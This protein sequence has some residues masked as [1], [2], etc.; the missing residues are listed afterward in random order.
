MKQVFLFGIARE[1]QTRCF[2]TVYTVSCQRQSCQDA[3]SVRVHPKVLPI[4][5][6]QSGGQVCKQQNQINLS[7]LLLFF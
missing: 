3:S 5:P 6:G 4:D 2:L 7:I 1:L